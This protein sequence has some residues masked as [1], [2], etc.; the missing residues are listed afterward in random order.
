MKSRKTAF[1]KA[2]ENTKETTNL[3]AE[4][5]WENKKDNLKLKKLKA[6]TLNLFFGLKNMTVIIM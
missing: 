1:N 3:R 5:I 4:K 2:K 6:A